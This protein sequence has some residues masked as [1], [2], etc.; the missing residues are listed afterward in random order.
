MCNFL[1]IDRSIQNN[2]VPYIRLLG[3]NSKGLEIMKLVKKFASLPIVSKYSHVT[4]L[5]KTAQKVFECECL[6]SDLYSL[7]SNKITICGKE[8]SFKII[9]NFE[10]KN[11]T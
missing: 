11:F 2:F 7:F 3:T 4:K 9:T 6:S 5:S 10:D 8:Q 1:G